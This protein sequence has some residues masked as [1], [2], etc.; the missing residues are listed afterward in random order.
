[1]RAEDAATRNSR[2][3]GAGQAGAAMTGRKKRGCTDEAMQACA[4][5]FRRHGAMRARVPWARMLWRRTH[6]FRTSP[7]PHVS[8]ADETSGEPYRGNVTSG[9][10][11]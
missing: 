7:S 5:Y 2:R 3:I 6:V 9:K 10:H 4:E 8:S 11:L 1:M